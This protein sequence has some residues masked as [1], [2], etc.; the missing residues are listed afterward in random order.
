M[1][2]QSEAAY[3][4]AGLQKQREGVAAIRRMGFGRQ[5]FDMVLR[6][7]QREFFN[8]LTAEGMG[9]EDFSWTSLV[10][11]LLWGEGLLDRQ[12]LTGASVTPVNPL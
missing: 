6:G 12:K 3:A 10:L 1:Y 7:G 8:P 9:A 4:G 2:P 5:S 11:D